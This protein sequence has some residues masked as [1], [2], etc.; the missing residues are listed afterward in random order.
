MDR[1]RFIE[2]KINWKF[3]SEWLVKGASSNGYD[4]SPLL[5]GLKRPYI[6]G[7]TIKGN[8]RQQIR[9]ITSLYPSCKPLEK[10]LFGEGGEYQGCLYFSE[11]LSE[12]SLPEQLKTNVRTRIALDKK[13]K[14]VKDEALIE[15]ELVT[16]Y[17]PLRST[18]IG[19][20]RENEFEDVIALISLSLLNMHSLGSGKSIGRGEI[21]MKYSEL[22]SENYSTFSVLY[23]NDDEKRTQLTFQEWESIVKKSSFFKEG[24]VRNE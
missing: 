11:A 20:V 9:K 10:Q 22:I 16:P 4:A 2:W 8:L 15:E 5:D 24:D 21:E 17:M 14:V 12:V 1:K 23:E 3:K 19:Y 18:I 7:S 13:R 6:P